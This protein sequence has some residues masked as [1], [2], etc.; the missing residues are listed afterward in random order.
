MGEL[1]RWYGAADP[2]HICYTSKLPY[3]GIVPNPKVAM[4]NAPTRFHRSC[5]KHNDTG[6]TDGER[7]VVDQ[8]PVLGYAIMCRILAHRRYYDAVTCGY[9]S[10]AHW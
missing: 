10:N 8:V 7:A 9:A 3:L 2:D 5:L 6:A 1:D 4:G